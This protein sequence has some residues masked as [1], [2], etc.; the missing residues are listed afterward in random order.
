MKLEQKI[1]FQSEFQEEVYEGL[2]AFPKYLSS[3]YFYDK[4]GDKLF[5]QIM[6]LPEYYLT[7]CE[8]QILSK[9]TSEIVEKFKSSSGFD[10][11]EL[12]AGDGKKTKLLLEE[13][14]S[15]N[16]NFSYKPIDISENVLDELQE[17]VKSLWP[18]ID[19]ETQQGTYFKVLE[20]IAQYT[21]RKKV[22][23]VLGSNIGNLSHPQ[24]IDFLQ[25]IQHS[26]HKD[27]LLFMGVD[28]KKHPATILKAYNDSAGVTEA[29]NKNLLDRINNEMDANFEPN[30]FIHWPTYDPESGT[31]KSFLVSNQ[32]QE[33]AINKLNLTVSF[34]K[35]E[36]IQTEI[37]QKYDDS[38][39]N[40]LAEEA[41]LTVV[42]QYEDD[43]G[44]FKD[45]IFKKK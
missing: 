29:F 5:Q 25:N 17:S 8:F 34:E 4:K 31:T 2:T 16:V 3:K 27:D 33:V 18:K 38:V 43:Q 28:Q 45:Y 37:S 26:M 15:N 44:Y 32:N 11:I 20:K 39:I 7:G 6:E 12:G 24:A 23:L 10:L 41:N 40:W 35:W 9:Y 14:M 21:Q 1:D 36:S 22:I 19:I 42:D 30:N 13:L